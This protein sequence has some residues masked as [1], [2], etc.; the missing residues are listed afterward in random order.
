MKYILIII[1]FFVVFACEKEVIEP[2]A[3]RDNMLFVLR[4]MI[5]IESQISLLKDEVKDSVKLELKNQLLE[6]YNW[7]DAQL[8][9]FK[10]YL[11][12]HPDISLELHDEVRSELKQLEGAL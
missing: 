5:L 3:T 10:A 2:P 12:N 6:Q 4:D 9:T 7:D 11:A 1:S 8:E